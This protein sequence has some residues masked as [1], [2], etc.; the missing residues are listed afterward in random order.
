MNMFQ[1]D[2]KLHS[3]DKDRLAHKVTLLYFVKLSVDANA[4]DLLHTCIK[5]YLEFFMSVSKSQKLHL[6]D[7]DRC[8]HF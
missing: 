3:Q 8:G 7:L 6:R 4:M 5:L 2:C 1:S